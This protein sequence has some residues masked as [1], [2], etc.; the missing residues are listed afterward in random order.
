MET[1]IK[2]NVNDITYKSELTLDIF[3][4]K[5]KFRKQPTFKKMSRVNSDIQ[6]MFA[7]LHKLCR[8]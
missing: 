4:V 2:G 1:Y 3:W 8:H 6:L 7:S 5:G